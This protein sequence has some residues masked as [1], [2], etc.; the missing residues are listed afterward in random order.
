MKDKDELLVI[1]EILSG[2]K[3]N[4]LFKKGGEYFIETMARLLEVSPVESPNLLESE[5]VGVEEPIDD[6]SQIRH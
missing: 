1:R 6:V 5:S 4:I 3:N 2:V